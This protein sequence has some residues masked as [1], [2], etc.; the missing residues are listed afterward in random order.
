[1]PTDQP[2]YNKDEA[3]RARDMGVATLHAGD[4]NKA[5]R[6][7]N[8]SKKLF[9]LDGIDEWIAKATKQLNNSSNNDFGSSQVPP[10]TQPVKEVPVEVSV[11]YTEEQLAVVNRII[12]FVD[13]YDKLSLS[14]TITEPEEINK[15]Y[16]QV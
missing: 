5:I 9:H 4:A 12:G 13:F 15:Q 14:C 10:P 2:V 16:R 6:L 7:F 3:E 11:T 1:M 8:R